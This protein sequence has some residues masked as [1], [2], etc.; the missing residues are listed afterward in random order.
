MKHL[1]E[2]LPEGLGAGSVPLSAA[3]VSTCIAEAIVH[4]VTDIALSREEMR[5]FQVVYD[6]QLPHDWDRK[7]FRGITFHLQ[8]YQWFV[9]SPMFAFGGFQ[10]LTMDFMLEGEVLKNGLIYRD[11]T[12]PVPGCTN[13]RQLKGGTGGKLRGICKSHRKEAKVIRERLKVLQPQVSLV[14]A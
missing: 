14:D 2:Y 7:S 4:G 12:C 5:M 3:Q 13:I 8:P 6:T 9:V 10:K 1:I 11:K